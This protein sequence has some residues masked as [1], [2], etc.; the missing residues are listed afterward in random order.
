MSLDIY[1]SSI[2][3]GDKYSIK[4]IIEISKENKFALEFSSGLLFDPE[5]EQIYINSEIKRIPHN[6]FPAPE[7]PF[8]LNLAS[9]N[10]LIRLNSIDHCINGLRLAKMSKSPFFSAH[11]GFCI[12]PDPLELGGKLKYNNNFKKEINFQYFISSLKIIL[13]ECECLKIPFLIENNVITIFNLQHGLNPLLGCTSQEIISVFKIIKSEYLGLLLDTAHLKV[14]CKTLNLNLENEL[15]ALNLY[16]K[17]I[18]H[19]ENDAFIDS[20]SPLTE[21]YWFLK[22]M[23][24]YRNLPHVIEVKNISIEQINLQKKILE[25]L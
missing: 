19:S 4:E 9:N 24:N 21:S 12:D 13:K 15:Q 22:F 20:N 10:D 25:N 11:F 23:Q 5:M 1:I 3:F 16:I 8:V 7:V 6:Y 2:A 18:H 17:A 14:S